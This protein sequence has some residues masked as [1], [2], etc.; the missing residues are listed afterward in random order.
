MSDH[1]RRSKLVPIGLVFVIVSFGVGSNF[2][3]LMSGTFDFDLDA[4]LN[5]LRAVFVVG[6]VC[7]AAGLLR[8]RSWRRHRN[9]QVLDPK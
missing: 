8:N 5:L 1:E 3:S 4:L 6:L 2:G 7:L 9:D